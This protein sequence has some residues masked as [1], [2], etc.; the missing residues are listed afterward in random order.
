MLTNV[1]KKEH[2]SAVTPQPDTDTPSVSLFMPFEPKMVSKN[3]IVHKLQ[4]LIIEAEQ[5]LIKTFSISAA[6]PILERLKSVVKNLDYSTHKKSTAIYVSAEEEKLFYL[7]TPLEEKVIVD[8]SFNIRALV[9]SKKRLQQHLVLVLG[10]NISRVYFGNGLH[11]VSMLT[12]TRKKSQSDNI[13]SLENFLRETDNNLGIILNYFPLLPLFVVGDA[14]ILNNY[15]KITRN[16]THIT[17]LIETSKYEMSVDEIKT[18]LQPYIINWEYI[19]MKHLHRRLDN[20]M[21][22]GK[23]AVGITNVIKD[24]NQRHAKLLVVEK[25]Y[26]VPVVKAKQGEDALKDSTL[27]TDAVD[28]VIE[29]VLASGGEVAFADKNVLEGY[30]HIALIY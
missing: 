9:E 17:Q 6:K 8:T 26:T 5:K 13:S 27:L 18:T 11:L 21:E 10:N 20:A 7:D 29:R 24:A 15:K 12:N 30:Q 4:S 28:E 3:E 22:S 25:G 2:T 23:I 19:R 14:D 1:L 16:E